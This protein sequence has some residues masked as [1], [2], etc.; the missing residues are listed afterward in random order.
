MMEEEPSSLPRPRRK[1]THYGTTIPTKKVKT[2]QSVQGTEVNNSTQ[3]NANNNNDLTNN[4]LNNNK[5]ME[6]NLQATNN[7][8]DADISLPQSTEINFENNSSKETNNEEDEIASQCTVESDKSE[9]DE[10]RKQA[11]MKR[12][13]ATVQLSSILGKN[14]G[15]KIA[16]VQNGITGIN[17]I[18]IR[19]EKDINDKQLYIAV[20]FENKEACT[21]ACKINFPGSTSEQQ[22]S[23]LQ[24]MAYRQQKNHSQGNGVK[25]WDM[26]ISMQ[27]REIRHLIETKF[28]EIAQFSTYTIGMWQ[29]ATVYFKDPQIEADVLAEWAHVLGDEVCRV[30]SI[31]TTMKQ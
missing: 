21:D 5:T 4:N 3:Q 19:T 24:V 11:N 12:Y 10:W 14:I 27:K 18:T 1:G 23:L 2:S 29:T 9:H 31:G 30:S 17:Y 7:N 20:Y 15:E 6:N 22:A 16:T 26:H 8:M 28:G 25:F 13:K